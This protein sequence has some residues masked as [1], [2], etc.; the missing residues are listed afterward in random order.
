MFSLTVTSKN[1]KYT[2]TVSVKLNSRGTLTIY[3]QCRTFVHE[4]RISKAVHCV[5][6]RYSVYRY[7]IITSLMSPFTFYLINP[8]IST[9][10]VL[11]LN[12]WNTRVSIP[13]NAIMRSWAFQKPI[14]ITRVVT[15]LTYALFWFND[16]IYHGL[17][18]STLWK[19][20]EGLATKKCLLEEKRLRTNHVEIGEDKSPR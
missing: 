5:A 14:S 8:K 13:G 10:I 16:I 1:N 12:F 20:I 15:L 6:L 17:G 2:I 9:R 18:V 7:H 3:W 4:V 19:L 11:S